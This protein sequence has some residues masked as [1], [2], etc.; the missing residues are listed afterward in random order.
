VLSKWWSYIVGYTNTDYA[1]DKDWSP[2]RDIWW[3]LQ[4]AVSLQSRLEKCISLSTTEI[5]YIHSSGW[6]L[7]GSVMDEK[8]LC[9]SWDKNKRSTICSVTQLKC[10][11]S[12]QEFK[13]S[14]LN[15]EYW[16]AIPV[17]S[18]S[19][20]FQV[21]QLEKIHTDRNGM[22]MMTQVLPKEKPEGPKRGLEGGNWS[23][24]E[25]FCKNFAYVPNLIPE[26]F[27]S[28]CLNHTSQRMIKVT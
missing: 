3:H 11:S 4:G 2:H 20:E 26:L 27:S 23:W 28:P 7:E 21:L 17:D 14:F 10:H 19:D 24:L 13:P 5:E 12:C 18:R 6:S 16:G 15:Q 8:L 22:D 1:E 25:F 9:K